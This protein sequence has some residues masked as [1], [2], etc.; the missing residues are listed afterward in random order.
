MIRDQ[1]SF[2]FHMNV[3]LLHT[4]FFYFKETKFFFTSDNQKTQLKNE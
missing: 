3:Q 2:F 4:G 1:G